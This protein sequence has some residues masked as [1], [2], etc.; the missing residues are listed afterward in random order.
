MEVVSMAK[1]SFIF[2]SFQTNQ[3]WLFSNQ[4]WLV[5]NQWWLVSNQ[6]RLVSNQW[7]LVSV[8][9]VDPATTVC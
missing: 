6:W 3:W 8:V 5:S 1:P 9:T 4:R 2:R 7:R